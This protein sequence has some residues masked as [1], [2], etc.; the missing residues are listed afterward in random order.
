MRIALVPLAGTAVHFIV[1]AHLVPAPRSLV[2]WGGTAVGLGFA[3]LL[4]SLA[5]SCRLRRT[6]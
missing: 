3:L 1:D 5:V 4:A 2:E 6:S